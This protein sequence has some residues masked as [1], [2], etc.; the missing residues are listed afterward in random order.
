MKTDEV[1][2]QVRLAGTTAAVP[3]QRDVLYKGLHVSGTNHDTYV[4]RYRHLKTEIPASME[5]N[6]LLRSFVG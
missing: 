3:T 6:E 5:A 2:T 1:S 4:D